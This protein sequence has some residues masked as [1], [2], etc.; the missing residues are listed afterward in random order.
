[1]LSRSHLPHLLHLLK[2][3]RAQKEVYSRLYLRPFLAEMCPIK[4]LVLLSAVCLSL[5][6]SRDSWRIWVQTQKKRGQE[7]PQILMSLQNKILPPEAYRSGEERR[8]RTPRRPKTCWLPLCPSRRQSVKLKCKTSLYLLLLFWNSPI[9]LPNNRPRSCLKRNSL[10]RK[11]LRPQLKRYQAMCM[12]AYLKQLSCAM[13]ETKLRSCN[14]Q[15]RRLR[16][17]KRR[18]SPQSLR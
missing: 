16:Q 14:L 4:M 7:I 13:R 3:R 10:P 6:L 9:H 5:G 17:R 2:L 8:V 12:M 18:G 11:G 1:M 15:L